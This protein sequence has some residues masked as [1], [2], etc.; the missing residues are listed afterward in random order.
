MSEMRYEVQDA[1]V[2]HNELHGLAGID[3]FI[4]KR[5]QQ[6]N[7]AITFD[8]DA[9]ADDT[10]CREHGHHHEH[11]H[12]GEPVISHR[13]KWATVLGNAAIGTA[14]LATG[15]LS[16]MSVAGDGIHNVGDMV[17]YYMQAEGALK[18]NMSV[19][20]QQRMRKISHW[21]LCTTSL[22]ISMKT[23]IDMGLD[24][25]HA[26][27]T[28]NIYSSGASLAL[29]GVL[30]HRLRKGIKGKTSA[31]TVHERDL[32]KHFWKIDIPSAS[33]AVAGAVLQKYNVSIEQTAAVLTGLIGGWA[34]R[35]TKKNL[36]HN[37]LGHLFGEGDDHDH[38]HD[39]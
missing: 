35:P 5:R 28:A 14:E 25:E 34:F 29:N 8:Q 18:P 6:T 22:G 23:G 24:N 37:C 31:Q 9:I 10:H 12:A 16:T 39:H 30:L 36:E 19:E 27:H 21:I 26:G 2:L 7:E 15:N 3:A 20:K 17:T 32:L 11:H 13:W 1:I 4:Q 38:P 33:L